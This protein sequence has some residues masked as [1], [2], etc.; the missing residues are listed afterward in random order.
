MSEV[1]VERS[2]LLM[3]AWNRRDAEAGVALWDPESVR[4]P[5]FE[6]VTEGRIYRGHAGIRQSVDDL[7]EW[8]EENHAEFSETHDLG[9]QVL[10]LGRVRFR[11]ASG[12][13]LEHEAGCLY[14][15]RDGRCVEERDYLGHAEALEAAGLSD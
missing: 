2:L 12:V 5:V 11:F 10:G 4:Y 3:D 13:E 9:D 15:W 6:R 8:C 7:A 1:N 14:T